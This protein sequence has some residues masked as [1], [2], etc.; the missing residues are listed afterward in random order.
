MELGSGNAL[1]W[2]SNL[3]RIPE[4]AQILL[5]DFSDGM[6]NDGRKVLGDDSKRFEFEIIDA[7]EIT[8]PNDIFDIVIANLMLYHIPDRKKAISE[9]SRV[10]K[11]EGTLYAS[12]YGVDNMKEFAYLLKSFNKNL[13]NPIEPFAREFGLENGEEQLER[14]FDEVEMINYIDS[15]EV[16]EAEPIIDYVLSFGSIKGN[17]DRDNLGGFKDYL[18]DILN[19]KGV[20][21]ITK[22]TGMFIARKPK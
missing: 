10:L 15:L 17:I 20:I 11:P 6:L 12:T 2:K 14:S 21:K 19:E 8:Y 7:Q 18:E 3:K 22:N 4:D 16:T 5:T 1:L 13:Y 9:I